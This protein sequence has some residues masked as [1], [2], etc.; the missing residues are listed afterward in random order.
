MKKRTV[1]II[2]ILTTLIIIQLFGIPFLGFKFTNHSLEFD[3]EYNSNIT[4]T[5]GWYIGY[6]ENYRANGHYIVD[7]NDNVASVSAQVTWIFQSFYEGS[8]QESYGSTENYIFSYSLLDGSYLSGTDQDFRTSN[9]KVWFHIPE[10]ITE[11][12]YPLLND[13]Y[14]FVG[15]GTIWVGNLMPFTGKKLVASGEF[16]RNDAYGQFQAKYSTEEFFT[17]EGFL[18]GEIYHET[19]TGYSEG[20][21]SEFQKDSYLFIT[22]SSYLR[23]FNMGIYLLTYWSPILFC[24]ILF[25]VIYEQYRWKP[26][27]IKTEKDSKE[28]II[29]KGFP[30]NIDLFLKSAYSDLIQAYIIRAK[31]QEKVIIS[32]HDKEKLKGIGFIEPDGKSGSFFGDYSSNLIEY[33]KVRY[34][35]VEIANIYGFK[36]IEQYDVLKIENIQQNFFNFDAGLIKPAS[37]EDIVPIMKLIANEDYGIANKR[38]AKWVINAMKSDLI[39]VATASFE[40]QWVKEIMLDI[41]KRKYPK[42]EIYSNKI[43]LG[44]GFVTP[45][46]RAGWSYGLYVHPGFRNKGIGRSLVYARLSILKELG[47]SYSITEIAEWNS[48]AKSIYDD[49]NPQNIGKVYLVGKKMPKV[50]MR[51]F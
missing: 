2:L 48:P 12:T 44:V 6:T 4:G 13:I 1:L 45:A 42:P 37:Q 34:A 14:T 22:S 16:S 41:Q 15:D 40:E 28:I 20:Y 35:F 10:G 36:T 24:L 31:A 49:L 8:L 11:T 27:I 30:K 29:E 43:L 39:M 5:G 46:E 50:K 51:R 26:R 47:C 18:I 9:M 32:A 33:A 23:P 17:S 3:Y 25:Y 21:W 38:Y 7:F 19:D